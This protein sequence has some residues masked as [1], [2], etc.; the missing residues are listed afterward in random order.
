MASADLED[1]YKLSPLQQGMLF[2]NL[3]HPEEDVYVVQFRFTLAGPLSPPALEDAWNRVLAQHPALRTSFHWEKIQ[4]P[5]QVVHRKVTL[6]VELHDLR[7]R[8]A[9]LERFLADD[10]ARGFDLTKA[11]LMRL[12]VLRTGAEEHVLVWTHHHL[13][14]DGWSVGLVVG[15]VL[16][17]YEAAVR[18]DSADLKR[19]RPFRDYIAWLRRQDL[20]AAE[21]FWRGELAGFIAPTPL[22]SPAPLPGRAGYGDRTMRL[23]LAATAALQALAREHQLTLSTVVQG[24]WGLLLSRMSGDEDVLFGTTVAGRPAELPGVESIVG[25]FI[26]TLPARVAVEPDA[27]L[28]PWLQRLQ[29]R[30]TAARQFEHSPL[31]EVQTWSEVPAGTPLFHSLFVFEN[32]PTA[33]E[34]QAARASLQVREIRQ[35]ETSNYPLSLAV[36]PPAGKTAALVLRVIWERSRFEDVEIVRLQE[37]LK[38]LLESFAAAPFRRLSELEML[39]PAERHQAVVEWNDTSVP[40]P[41]LTLDRLFAA[42][43]ERIPAAPAVTQGD[44]TLTYAD[45]D[46]WADRSA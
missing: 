26:N 19:A 43:A 24:A 41:S 14:L 30:Q 29:E 36:T 20:A 6:P 25:L 15:Q 33:D 12:A 38:T 10:R 45:L 44:R 34:R 27:P 32:F 42:Q 1:V 31:F 7:G 18:S 5:S 3:Y 4:A 39:T 8:E 46:D 23:T 35:V 21:R 13:L 17:L 16:A 37:H 11:P 9:D 2:H 40:L 22:G 28:V